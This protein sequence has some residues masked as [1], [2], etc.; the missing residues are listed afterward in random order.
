MLFSGLSMFSRRE[1]ESCIELS[2][3]LQNPAFKGQSRRWNYSV[4]SLHL[5][6][7]SCYSVRSPLTQTRYKIYNK[8]NF[9]QIW[10]SCVMEIILQHTQ[11]KEQN[12]DLSCKLG[13]VNCQMLKPNK[14]HM[15]RYYNQT[16]WG[17]VWKH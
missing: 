5:A 9:F 17:K 4:V 8:K 16:G 7:L 11:Q 15:G 1:D 10:T 6:L 14:E 2:A 3:M 12:H 13:W